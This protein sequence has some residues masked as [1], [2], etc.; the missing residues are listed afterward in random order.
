MTEPL[1]QQ[2]DPRPH[3]LY[4]MYDAARRLLY[5][6]ITMNV[7][8]RMADHRGEKPWWSEISTIELQH[9]TTRKE[10]EL[11]E[12]KAI[13]TERPAFNVMHVLREKQEGKGSRRVTPMRSLQ[14]DDRPW[15]ELGRCAEAI[16]STRSAVIR[17]L[18]LWYIRWPG[19][20]LPKRIDP[21]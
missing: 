16:G 4:R 12:K 3:V 5:V 20:K 19:A 6:G 7:P 9:F 13:R 14:M 2:L 11:A 10:V 8:A 18:V 17:D 1:P 21:S 15:A